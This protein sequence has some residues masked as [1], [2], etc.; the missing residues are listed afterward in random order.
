MGCLSIRAGNKHTV[1]QPVN[2]LP[3]SK[4]WSYT[5]KKDIPLSQL[6]LCLWLLYCSL[7]SVTGFPRPHVYR[8][9]NR[10]ITL[11]AKPCIF[12]ATPIFYQREL[13]AWSNSFQLVRKASPHFPER[14]SGCCPSGPRGNSPFPPARLGC[15]LRVSFL[16]RLLLRCTKGPCRGLPSQRRLGICSPVPAG[17]VHSTTSGEDADAAAHGA[18]SLIGPLLLLPSSV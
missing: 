1:I 18:I 5:D 2:L 4:N 6:A 3:Q 15:P 9:K 16:L 10:V 17:H 12:G 13:Q 11:L 7:F 8:S 14:R